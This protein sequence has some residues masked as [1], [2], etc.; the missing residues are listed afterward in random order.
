VNYVLPAG[1]TDAVGEYYPGALRARLPAVTPDGDH[2]PAF[3]ALA[4]E[5]GLAETVGF[6]DMQPSALDG[7]FRLRLAQVADGL[8]PL[9]ALAVIELVPDPDGAHLAGGFADRFQSGWPFARCIFAADPADAPALSARLGLPVW[10]WGDG[11]PKVLRTGAAAGQ[12]VAVVLQP[13]WGRSGSTTAYE[14]QAEGL[15]RSGRFTLR[16]FCDPSKRRGA[17][18]SALME[19]AVPENSANA[20]AHVEL[21]AVPDGPPPVNRA[22]TAEQA[23]AAYFVLAAECRVGDGAA[24]RVIGRAS[25]AIANHIDAIGAALRL[26]PSA[27]LLL[28]V[29]EDRAAAIRS[30]RGATRLR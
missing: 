20:G 2:G 4:A 9:D 23:W 30:G 16:L 7:F 8:G 26:A 27:A 13:V 5:I 12:P 1:A 22:T 21:L 25:L 28:D 17:T 6:A 15:V 24:A 18:L 11:E 19:R 10:P 3:A 14:N 29:H